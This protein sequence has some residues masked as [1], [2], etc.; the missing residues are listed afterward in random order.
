MGYVNDGSV[1]VIT[2]DIDHMWLR[3]SA[4]QVSHYIGLARDDVQVQMLIEGVIRRQIHFISVDPY[5]NSFKIALHRYPTPEDKLLRRGGHVA[6]GNYELDS[7]C[8]F[9]RLSYLYWETTKDVT[10]EVFDGEWVGAVR[11]IVDLMIVE[12][13]HHEKSPYTYIGIGDELPPRGRGA[14]VGFTGMTWSGFRP[15]DDACKYGYLIPANAMA[16]TT[17]KWAA[18][19]LQTLPGEAAKELV[20]RAVKLSVEIDDGIHKYGVKEVAGFGKVYVFEVDGLGGVNMMDD[21]NVPSL[22]SLSYMQYASPHDPKGEIAM[23]TRRWVL[24]KDNPFLCESGSFRGVGSPHTP[25]GNIWPM[26]ITVEALTSN[27][28]QE[29]RRLFDLL[30]ASDA[31]TF[32]MHESFAASNPSS[33][34]RHWFA[35]ANS[36][37][38]QAVLAKLE[39]LCP[40]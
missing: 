40:K 1:Y 14:P 30:Q 23:N 20:E 29:V 13:R 25:R 34:T 9:L 8:Y 28:K 2:G 33:F 32:K 6:T 5:A 24:S 4:A 22:L 21:A 12:Q 7:L 35:W 17:L 37:F 31:G 26:A 19:I 36:L 18:K 16:A 15:S 38:S 11:T 27:D 39:L 3:D 10:V